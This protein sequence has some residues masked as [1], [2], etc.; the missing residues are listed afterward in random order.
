MTYDTRLHVLS[1]ATFAMLLVACARSPESQRDNYL[2]RGREF[3]GKSNPSRAILEFK[4]AAQATP[5]HPEPWYQIGLAALALQDV[6]AA[7]ASFRKALEL[8]PKHVGAQLQLA[9]LMARTPSENLIKEAEQRLKALVATAP[10]TPEMLNAL[11]LAELKLGKTNDAVETLERALKTAPQQLVASILLARARLLQKNPKEAEEVLIRACDSDPK[12]GDARVVLGELYVSQGRLPD[13]ET[14]FQRALSLDSDNGAALINLARLQ[15]SGGRLQEAETTV[16]HLSALP[17]KAYQATYGLFLY[18]QGRGDD[19]VREFERLVKQDPGDRAARTRLVSLYR[20]LTRDSEAEKILTAALKGNPRDIDALLQR[21][22]MYI[23]GGKHVEA[24]SDLNQV[25]RVKPDSGEAHYAMGRLFEARGATRRYRQELSEAVR[26]NPNLLAVRLELVQA[27]L[28][29]GEPKAAAEA[30]ATMPEHQKNLTPAL[31][32]RNWVL[33]STGELAEM[34]K[35]IDLALSRERSMDLLI[36]DGLWKLRAGNAQ[37]ARASFD[38]ALNINPTDLRALAAL[39]AA[40][41]AQKQPAMALQKVKEFAA[42]NPKSAPLQQFLGNMLMA[43]GDYPQAR[44]ALVAAKTA[45]PQAVAAELSLVTL[46]MRESKLDDAA[47]R[48]KTILSRHAGN[49][50][51]RLWLGNVEAVKGNYDDAITHF[52]KV[53]ESRPDDGDAMNNLAY[54][55][56]DRRKQYDEALKYAQRAQ[57]LA[58][59]DPKY[60]DTVGWILYHKGVY[61][62]AVQH[63]ERA[64]SKSGGESPMTFHLAM[65]YAKAGNAARA[66]KTLETALKRYPNAPEATAASELV[67]NLR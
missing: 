5:N 67:R 45:D 54:L 14:Q 38:E 55:L 60:A 19:A 12:S 23:S 59:D 26:L 7:S 35:G 52:R 25:L 62:S 41:A 1:A 42:K 28:L 4:N 6:R 39:R 36:Q 21:G 3:L 40:Y 20:A 29:G 50:T 11:A 32:Q 24:E 31:V 10:I 44:T 16:K 43:S 46:D 57:E 61:S 8:D 53:L 33:W 22:E 37:S 27:L 13:A 63:L 47:N 2:A 48:L 15:I 64:V 49:A 30:L 56:A 65:A 51:A 58:P 34:R 9:E 18:Q 17:D 66:R